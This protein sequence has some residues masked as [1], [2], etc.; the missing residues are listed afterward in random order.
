MTTNEMLNKGYATVS[1][2]EDLVNELRIARQQRDSLLAALRGLVTLCQENQSFHDPEHE[3]DSY[4]VLVHAE[5]AIA[6]A[7]SGDA[8][9]QP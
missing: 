2:V 9:V 7:T 1:A 6:C 3:P 8:E 5:Q 4:A